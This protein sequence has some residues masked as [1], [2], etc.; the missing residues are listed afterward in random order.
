MP[1]LGGVLDEEE[2]KLVFAFLLS[3]PGAPFIYYGDEIG[4]RYQK[5]LKSVEGGYSRTGTRTPMQWDDSENAGFS[6]APKSNLYLPVDPDTNRP[7]VKKQ[8]ETENSL[9]KEVQKLIAIRQSHRALQSDGKFAFVYVEDHAYPL[10]YKRTGDGESILVVINPTDKAVSCQIQLP[11][12]G[13]VLYCNGASPIY[14][15]GTVT[16]P[17]ESAAFIVLEDTP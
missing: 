1:R 6:A 11:K 3:M 8:M 10:I 17:E 15:N 12:F 14:D 2:I 16:V 7:T 9:W 13:E 5:G 4:M